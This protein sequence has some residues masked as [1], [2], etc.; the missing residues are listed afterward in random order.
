[1]L[2]NMHNNNSTKQHVHRWTRVK[3]LDGGREKIEYHR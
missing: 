1:M 3:L 2:R